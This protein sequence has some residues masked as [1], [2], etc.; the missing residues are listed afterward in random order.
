MVCGWL[1][2]H[3]NLYIVK[4]FISWTNN[5]FDE[6]WSY[7]IFQLRATALILIYYMAES[8]LAMWLVNLRSVTCYTGQNS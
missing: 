1:K 5:V 2:V 6:L 4:L 7:I 8:V 3:K